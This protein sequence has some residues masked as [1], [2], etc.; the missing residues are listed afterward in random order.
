VNG[1]KAFNRE[2][3][4][5]GAKDEKKIYAAEDARKSQNWRIYLG[6]RKPDRKCRGYF[7]KHG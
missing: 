3:R 5:G 4:K 7:A 6:N 1:A 2:V